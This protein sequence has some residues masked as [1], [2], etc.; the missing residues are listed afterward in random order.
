M[1]VDEQSAEQGAPQDAAASATPAAHLKAAA[2]GALPRHLRPAGAP[3]RAH[4]GARCR[5]ASVD[6]ERAG[7]LQRLGPLPH[8]PGGPAPDVGPAHDP[9]LQAPPPARPRSR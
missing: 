7:S 6:R 2:Q 8:T 3:R 1:G 9:G 5:G 4:G